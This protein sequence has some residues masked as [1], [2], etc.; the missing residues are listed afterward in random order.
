MVED[1][2]QSGVRSGNNAKNSRDLHQ[3]SGI[4]YPYISSMSPVKLMWQVNYQMLLLVFPNRMGLCLIELNCSKWTYTSNGNWVILFETIAVWC[5]W[6]C[7]YGYLS[8]LCEWKRLFLLLDSCCYTFYAI[9]FAFQFSFS[10]KQVTPI[11]ASVL[12]G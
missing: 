10:C 6:K 9:P 5:S 1:S 4:P 12:L 11:L 2:F 3:E 7:W 8:K